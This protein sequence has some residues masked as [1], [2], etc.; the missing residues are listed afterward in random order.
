MSFKKLFNPFQIYTVIIATYIKN[1]PD[2]FLH[3]MSSTVFAC[4]VVFGTACILK[5]FTLNTEDNN[6]GQANEQEEQQYQLG[7]SCIRKIFLG[8]ETIL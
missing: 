5:N 6:N 4:I 8:F 1:N 3:L 7:R 2:V